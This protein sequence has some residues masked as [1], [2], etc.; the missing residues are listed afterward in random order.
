MKIT[1]EK[2]LPRK[3]N[4]NAAIKKYII[5]GWETKSTRM[6]NYHKG[7]CLFWL[8]LPVNPLTVTKYSFGF[9]G[10]RSLLIFTVLIFRKLTLL[11]YE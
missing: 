7:T 6:G 11:T 8:P 5:N 3:N 9:Y 2:L 10:R 1:K 4:I